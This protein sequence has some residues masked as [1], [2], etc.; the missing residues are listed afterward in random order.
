MSW[1]GE[2]C[3]RCGKRNVIGYS[4]SDEIWEQVVKGRWNVL[5]PACF[6]EEAEIEEV[7]Y[8]FF[9]FWHVTWSAH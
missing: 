5:C 8:F 9:D 3:K 1:Q 4:V 7:S 6:D 2:V